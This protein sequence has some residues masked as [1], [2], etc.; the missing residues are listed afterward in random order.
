M[1][2][3]EGEPRRRPVETTRR[4]GFRSR[5]SLSRQ[6]PAWASV[7]TPLMG[8]AIAASSQVEYD[9]GLR[10][11]LAWLEEERRGPVRT[12]PDIDD[13]F[14][15]YAWHVYETM[16][17]R[18]RSRLH[19]AIYAIEHYLPRCKGGLVGAYRSERGWR[20]WNPPSSHPPIDWQ[21]TCYL[22]Q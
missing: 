18:G 6:R 7:W 17:G 8:A 5:M 21:L 19:N 4:R 3:F 2:T 9:R 14:C 16:G 20:L 10:Y 22:A 11:F 1:D 13:A 15:E 12:I